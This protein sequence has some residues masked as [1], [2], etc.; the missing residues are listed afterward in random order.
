MKGCTAPLDL[1]KVDHLL[2]DE[3]RDIQAAVRLLGGQ[4]E[5]GKSCRRWAKSIYVN[6]S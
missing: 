2:S 3:E 6:C 1:L 4:P 5:R